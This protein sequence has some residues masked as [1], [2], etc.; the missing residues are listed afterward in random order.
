MIPLLAHRVPCQLEL[1]PVARERSATAQAAACETERQ[2]AE[3]GAP[4]RGSPSWQVKKI[5][6]RELPAA[7]T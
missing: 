1:A 5:Q 3:G 6:F 2:Q 7:G 4:R